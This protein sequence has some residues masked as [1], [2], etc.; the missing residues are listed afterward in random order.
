MKN[1]VRGRGDRDLCSGYGS[2]GSPVP[3][4]REG[5]S[6]PGVGDREASALL[7]Y[8]A[9]VLHGVAL[10]IARYQE[11]ARGREVAELGIGVGGPVREH[12]DVVLE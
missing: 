9:H 5:L 2:R 6:R 10:E 7:A 11:A 12:L 1:L 3:V 8:H 4:E